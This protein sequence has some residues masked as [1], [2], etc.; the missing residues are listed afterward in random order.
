M[1]NIQE[2]LTSR[3]RCMNKTTQEINKEDCIFHEKPKNTEAYQGKM[4]C[5]M[6]V[7]TKECDVK[8]SD[9]TEITSNTSQK[10]TINY[11]IA[12]KDTQKTKDN[13]RLIIPE[14]VTSIYPNSKK[15]FHRAV[16]H[17]ISMLIKENWVVGNA[18]SLSLM[19]VKMI[20]DLE[21]KSNSQS[22]KNHEFMVYEIGPYYEACLGSALEHLESKVNSECSWEYYVE[23]IKIAKYFE[24]Q[25]D[26]S[27][28]KLNNKMKLTKLY[29]EFIKNELNY[30]KYLK[31]YPLECSA[32]YAA[33]IL[34]RLLSNDSSSFH[35]GFLDEKEVLSFTK[36]KTTRMMAVF[37]DSDNRGTDRKKEDF[38]YLRK[39][40][41]SGDACM[42]TKR[43][44][45]DM[46]KDQLHTLMKK[47]NIDSMM[48]RQRICFIKDV[49]DI[50]EQGRIYCNEFHTLYR[51]V[52]KILLQ[53]SYKLLT[54][55]KSNHDNI[56]KFRE[57]SFELISTLHEKKFLN[58]DCKFRYD[59][60]I[61]IKRLTRCA[62][63][64]RVLMYSEY[65]QRIDKIFALINNNVFNYSLQAAEM[66]KNIF[67]NEIHKIESLDAAN[68]LLQSIEIIKKT[69]S[70]HLFSDIISCY[71]ECVCLNMTMNN[72]SRRLEGFL[73]KL[74]LVYRYQFLLKN[75][76]KMSDWKKIACLI[77]ASKILE[78]SKKKS[79]NIDDFR[80]LIIVKFVA[81]KVP[82][83]FVK[84]LL[85]RIMIQCLTEIDNTRNTRNTSIVE[86]K[87]I[88]MLS[89]WVSK[90]KP[91]E[92]D[93]EQS[94]NELKEK[95]IKMNYLWSQSDDTSTPL[96]FSGELEQYASDETEFLEFGA[97]AKQELQSDSFFQVVGLPP[98][99]L[100]HTPQPIITGMN[101]ASSFSPHGG[102]QT[103][104]E[105]MQ[106]VPALHLPP[107]APPMTLPSVATMQPSVLPATVHPLQAPHHAASIAQ[108]TDDRYRFSSIPLPTIL[109]HLPPPPLRLKSVYQPAPPPECIQSQRFPSMQYRLIPP[110][111][112]RPEIP[113]NG[114]I[115]QA[116]ARPSVEPMGY[117]QL[118]PVGDWTTHMPIQNRG[119]L[120]N[121]EEPVYYQ[122]DQSISFNQEAECM[123]AVSSMHGTMLHQHNPKGDVAPEMDNSRMMKMGL[124]QLHQAA[125][126]YVKQKNC[127]VSDSTD[128]STLLASLNS[129]YRSS[130]NDS[131]NL[132]ATW[133][134]MLESNVIKSEISRELMKI[135]NYNGHTIISDL[136]NRLITLQNN[137][138]NV[139]NVNNLLMLRN[140]LFSIRLFMGLNK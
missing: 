84:Y 83:Q 19:V 97:I 135:T 122:Q 71:D 76:Y 33:F 58:D 137:A 29:I 100:K 103:I 119:Y 43:Y 42:K 88:K 12:V 133:I 9:Q 99:N 87:T 54:A 46:L 48:I 90:L 139:E 35:Y 86:I 70:G 140:Y 72:L 128:E 112:Y 21:V 27:Q 74:I 36:I 130:F 59:K 123:S 22:K 131:I 32:K 25:S 23:L 114:D 5:G 57:E 121:S 96:K 93:M 4:R 60:L 91:N 44:C 111:T 31:D 56:D 117:N 127:N 104:C 67:D 118:E 39:K 7:E 65:Q 63:E 49:A 106:P 64:T 113:L 41:L 1:S 110:T 108:S 37:Q 3:Y 82:N 14:F 13:D 51:D 125:E 47:T 75:I 77:V 124:E 30:I 61:K 24:F 66:T 78:I 11:A 102:Q 68:S 98:C 62:N 138:G 16:C 6:Y 116:L 101:P 95:I 52:K 73:P 26:C 8:S 79:L 105:R 89:F 2:L 134:T 132:L 45:H 80:F 120:I 18:F 38:D 34:E 109:R 94:I 28:T 15:Y 129:S 136:F 53:S 107:A 17:G 126:L 20:S 92:P 40:I 10:R 55:L 85:I 81:P 50:A 69:L 115:Q